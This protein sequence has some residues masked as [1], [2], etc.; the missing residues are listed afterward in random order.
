M[1][2]IVSKPD[3]FIQHFEVCIFSQ[4]VLLIQLFSI[5]TQFIKSS[6]DVPPL[7][8]EPSESNY[9]HRYQNCPSESSSFTAMS[10]LDW[11]NMNIF[12]IIIQKHEII[13]ASF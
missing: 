13:L 10:P 6:Q 5:S 8:Y 1:E 11:Y 12:R 9:N 4:R 3:Q 7:G 2:E